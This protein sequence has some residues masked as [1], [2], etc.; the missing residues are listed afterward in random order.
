MQGPMEALSALNSLMSKHVPGVNASSE[1][2]RQID[3]TQNFN[4][5]MN[6]LSYNNNNIGMNNN[7]GMNTNT[8]LNMNM[9]NTMGG[10]N[11]NGQG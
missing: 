10:M 2:R 3:K 7:N 5:G 6:N 1:D 11:L 4:L 9:G 8:N